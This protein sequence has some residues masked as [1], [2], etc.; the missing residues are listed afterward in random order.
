M[1]AVDLTE[2]VLEWMKR[3]ENNQEFISKLPMFEK[4]LNTKFEK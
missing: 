2:S 1:S 4:S 3:T